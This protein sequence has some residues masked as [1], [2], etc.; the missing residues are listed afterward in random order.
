MR[1]PSDGNIISAI[2]IRA[3]DDNNQCHLIDIVQD[4]TTGFCRTTVNGGSPLAVGGSGFEDDSVSVRQRMATRVRIG[5]PNCERIPL[6]M[7]VTCQNMSGELM[8]RF[9]ISRGVNLRPS[10][11]GLLGKNMSV[12]NLLLFLSLSLYLSS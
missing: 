1:N 11:H 7:W 4:Q 2:G 6:V 3:S 12:C 8:M 9:D 10:S 5:V